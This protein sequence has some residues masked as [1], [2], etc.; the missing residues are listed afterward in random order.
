MRISVR[1]RRRYPVRP[2]AANHELAGRLVRLEQLGPQPAVVCGWIW[3]GRDS[4]GRSLAAGA[5][6]VRLLAGR[7]IPRS[8]G[9]LAL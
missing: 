8:V 2:R 1:A 3:D 6:I 5:Y 7:H 9:R 4:G